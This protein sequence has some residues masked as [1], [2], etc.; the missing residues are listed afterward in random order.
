MFAPSV[1]AVVSV[2]LMLGFLAHYSFSVTWIEAAGLS[3]SGIALPLAAQRFGRDS[4][5]R[6]VSIRA[7]LRSILSET[8]Q[9][10]GELLIA[11][12]AGRQI[13]AVAQSGIALVGQQRLQ[14]WIAGASTALSGLVAQLAL[15][16]ALIVTIPLIR[17]P[18]HAQRP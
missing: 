9:G 1:A 6:A 18:A 15:W 5:H 8:V 11:Q 7:E 12:A 17:Q 16:G 4:A 10:L 13:A 3:A 14:A 2:A